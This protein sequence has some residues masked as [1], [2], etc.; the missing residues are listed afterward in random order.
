MVKNFVYWSKTLDVLELRDYPPRLDKELPSSLDWMEEISLRLISDMDSF[1]S[2]LDEAKR[3]E[4]VANDL[5]T[6]GLNP[7]EDEIVGICLSH[8]PSEGVYIPLRHRKD[9]HQNLDPEVVLPM[10]QEFVNES[11]QLFFNAKFDVSFYEAA[12]VRVPKYQDASISCYMLNTNR[13]TLGLKHMAQV[14]LGRRMLEIT[15]V[16]GAAAKKEV[17]FA[18]TSP[19]EAYRYGASDAVCTLEL[20]NALKP[21]RDE[22][23]VIYKI[24]S[25]AT[26]AV[27]VMEQN[28]VRI[29][30]DYC[31]LM[32]SYLENGILC[33]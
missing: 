4:I 1:S 24:E 12:G 33:F 13:K 10:I 6:T 25:A 22:Q 17:D 21:I 14:V 2:F 9:A 18:A 29:D 15:E 32:W 19:S 27:R 20:H 16:T 8:Q 30:T 7:E 31:R 11:E 3:A 26:E 23:A 28:R 5:E